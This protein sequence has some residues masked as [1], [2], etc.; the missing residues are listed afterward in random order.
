MKKHHL[1]G[2]VTPGEEEYHAMLLTLGKKIT[3]G[4]FKT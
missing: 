1:F 3:S 4:K 2:G